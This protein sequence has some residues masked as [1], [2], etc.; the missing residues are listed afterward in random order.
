MSAAVFRLPSF[1]GTGAAVLL[2]LLLLLQGHFVDN[3]NSSKL[4]PLIGQNSAALILSTDKNL[5]LKTQLTCCSRRWKD[6]MKC[7]DV[8]DASRPFKVPVL[9]VCFPLPPILKII[10]PCCKTNKINIML[11]DQFSLTI[12]IK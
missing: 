2:L 9:T 7:K 1:L 5:R 4:E 12:L 3:P 6:W 11:T 8:A 10:R